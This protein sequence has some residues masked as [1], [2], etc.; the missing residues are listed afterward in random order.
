MLITDLRT[1][2][3]YASSWE[4]MWKMIVKIPLTPFS[5]GGILLS[6]EI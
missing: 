3:S 2:F 4:F 1:I 5:K 6:A